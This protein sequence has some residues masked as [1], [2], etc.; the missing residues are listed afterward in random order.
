M[1]L[2]STILRTLIAASIRG[3]VSV[4]LPLLA[5][6]RRGLERFAWGL[7]VGIA[8]V[9]GALLTIVILYQRESSE[10]R[11]LL[12]LAASLAFAGLLSILLPLRRLVRQLRDSQV[13]ITAH[14]RAEEELRER[15]RFERLLADLSALF[16]SVRPQ[17]VD[18]EVQ[19]A[20][21]AIVEFLHAHRA[22]FV[23]LMA[24]GTK[25]RDRP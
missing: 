3:A 7:G 21:Q 2:D 18:A 17:E 16:V 13:D 24:D 10:G 14:E 20:L 1:T 8:A 15:Y 23:E 5:R 9:V 4:P 12:V 19:K 11:S 6:A 22:S 25:L